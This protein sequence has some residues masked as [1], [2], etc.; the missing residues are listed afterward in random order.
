M[1]SS[2]CPLPGDAAL[3]VAAADAAVGALFVATSIKEE[4]VHVQVLGY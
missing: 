4:N 2:I 1:G 3:P